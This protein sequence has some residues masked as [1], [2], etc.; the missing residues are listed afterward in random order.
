MV[1]PW[2]RRVNNTVPKTV[3][4]IESRPGIFSGMLNAK[5]IDIGIGKPIVKANLLQ[6][7]IGRKQRFLVPEANIPNRALVC[8]NRLLGEIILGIESLSVDL[9]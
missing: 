2:T 8:L 5:A 4:T 6:L 7:A 1:N 3:A 9:V